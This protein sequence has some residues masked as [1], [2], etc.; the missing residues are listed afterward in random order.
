MSDKIRRLSLDEFKAAVKNGDDAGS[1]LVPKAY[2]AEEIKQIGNDE[3]LSIQFVISTGDVDRDNDT[4]DPLGWDLEPFRKAGTVLWAHDASL[5]PIA[6]PMATFL[7]GDKL[8]SI[9]QFTPADMNHPLGQGFG[10]TVF[11]MFKEGFLRAVSVGF[12]PTEFMFSE[13]RGGMD[14]TAQELLE[15]SAVPVP[16]NRQALVEARSKGINIKHLYNWAEMVLDTKQSLIVPKDTMTE[17]YKALK[18]E[19][20]HQKINRAVEEAEAE[21][22]PVESEEAPVTETDPVAEED[23]IEEKAVDEEPEEQDEEAPLAA[24]EDPAQK[25]VDVLKAIKAVEDAENHLV[26]CIEHAVEAV[27]K[28]GRVLSANNENRL[29]EARQLLDEVLASSGQDEDEKSIDV[30]ELEDDVTV[31]S[32]DSADF[33]IEIEES[34]TEEDL[35]QVDDL[36]KFK[37]ELANTVHQ[38]TMT[39]LTGRLAD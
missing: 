3:D 14:F 5:P 12:L 31:E 28:R 22:T 32:K 6:K 29:Q 13:D 27:S 1:V 7:E 24:V 9:A 11:R 25:A 23:G 15:F 20:F 16:S 38:A 21:E 2:A 4:V 18:E 10:H 39:K 34:E 19:A 33:T 26:D 36:E 30:F 8:K 37:A 17:V 35:F